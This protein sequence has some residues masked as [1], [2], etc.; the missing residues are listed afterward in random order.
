[1]R[2]AEDLTGK[3]FGRWQVIGQS[4]KDIRGRSTWKCVCECG[5][6][7]TVR[8][9]LLTRNISKSCG[10]LA[11]E[12]S[13][14]RKTIHGHCADGNVN[15]NSTYVTWKSMKQRC[16]NTTDKKKKKNYFDKGITICERW[17]N[18]FENFL[19]DMGERP[20][21]K[22][23]DRIDGKGNYEPSNCRWADWLEQNTNKSARNV[24]DPDVIAKHIKRRAQCQ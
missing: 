1:M 13:A 5:T 23:L 16:I 4:E 17:A 7:R 14:Q 24:T 3:T 19:A 20:D 11:A 18:S 10:C 21:G 8:N 6:A 2:R 12:F 22:T 9:D 15:G